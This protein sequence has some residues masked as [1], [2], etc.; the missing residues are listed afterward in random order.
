MAVPTIFQKMLET[1]HTF[2]IEK[3][4]KVRN[5]CQSF[6]LMVSGSAALPINVLNEWKHVTGPN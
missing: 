5:A 2:P 3:Q 1:Y 6:R 4:N